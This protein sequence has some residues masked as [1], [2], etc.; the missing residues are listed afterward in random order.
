MNKIYLDCSF[1]LFLGIPPG[2]RIEISPIWAG[3]KKNIVR[4]L[5]LV[6]ESNKKKLLS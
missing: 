3:R 2:G 6:K 1:P 4:E 5:K